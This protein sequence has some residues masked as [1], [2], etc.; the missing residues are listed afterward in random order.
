MPLDA[1]LEDRGLQAAKKALLPVSRLEVAGLMI[2]NSSGDAEGWSGFGSYS[3]FGARSG[4]C[5]N[6]GWNW[7]PNAPISRVRQQSCPDES[8]HLSDLTRSASRNPPNGI[9]WHQVSE[10]SENLR[11][12]KL[13]S[14]N[15]ET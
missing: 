9:R 13:R 6:S 7:R 10:A 14:V 12:N 8:S 1:A 2:H 5:C 3:G 11:L 4:G 15:R